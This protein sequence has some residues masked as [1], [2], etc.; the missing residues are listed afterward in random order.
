MLILELR[1]YDPEADEPRTGWDAFSIDQA[2]AAGRK[3]YV[4]Q[5]GDIWTNG[6]REYVGKIRKEIKH[7]RSI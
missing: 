1:P 4:D 5:F 6:R 3:L 2:K 7:G